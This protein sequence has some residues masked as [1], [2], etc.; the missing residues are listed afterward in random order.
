[1][2]DLQY[3][4]AVIIEEFAVVRVADQECILDSS[5]K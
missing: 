3:T 1:M 4:L 2:E 5:C